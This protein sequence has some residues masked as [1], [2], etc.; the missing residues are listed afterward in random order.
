MSFFPNTNAKSNGNNFP[1]QN[2]EC[3]QFEGVI[4]ALRPI[5]SN[6]N[7]TVFAVLEL[8]V[9]GKPGVFQDYLNFNENKAA[10]SMGFL[11]SHCKA[12]ILSAG[13]PISNPDAEKD[14][15]WVEES[16][17]KL[18]K[19]GAKLTFQQSANYRGQ[20]SINYVSAGSQ[21]ENLGF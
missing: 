2:R 12:A 16:Y 3:G 8:E 21:T 19:N 11:V 6:S 5:K 4:K 10:E 15:A 1:E 14:M 17:N 9:A 18:M 13:L 20:L 7:S